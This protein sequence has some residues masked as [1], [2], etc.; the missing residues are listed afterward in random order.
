M[1]YTL[2]NAIT[3]TRRILK[4]T[5]ENV[6]TNTDI[7]AFINESILDLQS[8]IP[9]YFTDLLEVEVLEDEINI[10]NKYKKIMSIFAASRCFSQDEQHY[11][12]SEKMN[13]YES[14]KLDMEQKILSSEEYAEK[15]SASGSS[16]SEYIV[17]EYYGSSSDDVILPLEP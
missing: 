9:E 17:N 1:P 8:T 16:I 11:R 4:D 6:W 5:S 13:E 7:T 10:D 2:E 3:D 15:V 12:A 14:R